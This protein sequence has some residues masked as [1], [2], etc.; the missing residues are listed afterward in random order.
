MRHGDVGHIPHRRC[1]I[2]D[3]L[4]VDRNGR[5]PLQDHGVCFRFIPFPH[6][7]RVPVRPS[8]VRPRARVSF[9]KHV[10][11]ALRRSVQQVGAEA[12][13]DFPMRRAVRREESRSPFCLPA[14]RMDGKTI[15]ADAAANE[16]ELSVCVLPAPSTATSNLVDRSYAIQR[17]PDCDDRERKTRSASG[18]RRLHFCSP[19]G[20]NRTKNAETRETHPRPD[21]HKIFCTSYL[22]CAQWRR[23]EL[24]PRLGWRKAFCERTLWQVHPG[25]VGSVSGL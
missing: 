11:G 18:L 3:A 22:R 1:Q 16:F 21:R 10:G 4:D 14:L 12:V 8:D 5:Q 25:A 19:S 20:L 23:R 24:H 9:P 7:V 15:A 6:P 17:W 2:V 13:S